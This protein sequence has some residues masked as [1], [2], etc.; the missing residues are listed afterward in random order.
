MRTSATMYGS[1]DP[2]RDLGC[3]RPNLGFPKAHH[4]PPT[5][6]QVKRY[7]SI[8]GGVADDLLDPLGAELWTELLRNRSP[9]TFEQPAMP[10]VAV[11]EDDQPSTSKHEVWST[12]ELLAAGSVRME[13]VA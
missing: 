9:S 6:T 13:S 8:P 3:I 1:L 7:P 2:A 5:R 12:A 11:D 10:E 4:A